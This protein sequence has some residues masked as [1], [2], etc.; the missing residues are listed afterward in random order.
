MCYNDEFV[1][2]YIINMGRTTKEGYFVLTYDVIPRSSIPPGVEFPEWFKTLPKP[3]VW[4][5]WWYI[6]QLPLFFW[7]KPFDKALT[8]LGV[9]D[10]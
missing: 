1:D 5:S 6:L 7:T 2:D 10:D 9:H 4:D 8:H 3:S